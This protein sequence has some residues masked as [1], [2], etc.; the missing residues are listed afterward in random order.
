MASEME[1]SLKTIRRDLDSFQHAGFML[2]QETGPYGKKRWRLSPDTE[3]LKLSFDFEEAAALYLGRQLLEPLAGTPFWE[4]AQRAFRKIR[5][6]FGNTATNYL[7]EFSKTFHHQPFGKSDYSEKHDVIDTL[8]VAIEDR[9]A[10]Q[11][12]YQSLQSAELKKY[13]VHPYGMTY[14]HSSLYLIGFHGKKKKV[15]HWKVDRIE[16]AKPDSEPFILIDNFDLEKHLRHSFGI[17]HGDEPV[18][19]QIRFAEPVTRYVQESN[20]HPTQILTS[21]EDGS[22]LAEFKLT[23]THEV[24]RWILSFGQH[25]EVLE[26][27]ELRED[28]IQEIAQMQSG[29][30][31]SNQMCKQE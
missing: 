21:Q 20:W 8:M 17:F 28:I 26:P 11:I 19:V 24:S 1:V 6:Y 22:L 30:E 18:Q 25:A 4:A 29:Y 31:A 13:P 23:D 16:S 3:G 12:G 9:R 15:C 2:Y 27:K 14:H 5:S 7:E 10:C